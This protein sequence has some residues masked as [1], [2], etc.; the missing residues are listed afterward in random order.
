MPLLY[1][2]TVTYHRAPL[3]PIIL[4]YTDLDVPQGIRIVPVMSSGADETTETLCRHLALYTGGQFVFLTDDSGVGGS[5]R[6]PVTTVDYEVKP[7]IQILNDVI[8]E[9]TT[10]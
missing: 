6:E 4:H 5:H 9:Y 8:T 1:S 10:F 3:L 7:L 2:K